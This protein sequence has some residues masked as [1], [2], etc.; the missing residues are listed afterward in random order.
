MVPARFELESIISCRCTGLSI[1]CSP[2]MKIFFFFF[3][4]PVKGPEII[5]RGERLDRPT[6]SH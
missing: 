2:I 4:Q 5:Q 6:E 1:L 3:L